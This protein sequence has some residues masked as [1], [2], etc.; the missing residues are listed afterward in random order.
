LK[1]PEELFQFGQGLIID[2]TNVLDG[3][4]KERVERAV[5]MS[6]FEICS[7]RVHAIAK[8]NATFHA[9][10]ECFKY[11]DINKKPNAIFVQ[12]SRTIQKFGDF[13]DSLSDNLKLERF[14]FFTLTCAPILN[15]QL[16][17]V[18]LGF[19]SKKYSVMTQPINCLDCSEDDFCSSQ[20][21]EEDLEDWNAE[22]ISDDV[23]QIME[24]FTSK[25]SLALADF[26][27]TFGIEYMFDEVPY[28]LNQV[29]DSWDEIPAELESSYTDFKLNRNGILSKDPNLC[30]KDECT[31]SVDHG[32]LCYSHEDICR[33]HDCFDYKDEGAYCNFHDTE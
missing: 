6:N 20:P 22:Q 19:T 15:E 10:S 11:V 13:Q 28:I 27:K 1:S 30:S 8:S 9:V 18:S 32:G 16:F 4:Y 24:L 31:D 21:S 17:H 33:V 3:D 2:M 23:L 26:S 5:S 7:V 29:Y 25:W 12:P 14:P